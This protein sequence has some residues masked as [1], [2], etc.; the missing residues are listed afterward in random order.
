MRVASIEV[1]RAKVEYKMIFNEDADEHNLFDLYHI[2]LVTSYGKLFGELE[3]S[4]E[5]ASLHM[6]LSNSFSQVG[7]NLDDYQIINMIMCIIR[8]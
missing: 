4:R 5:M 3:K 1:E 2:G 6:K 7:I 8:E